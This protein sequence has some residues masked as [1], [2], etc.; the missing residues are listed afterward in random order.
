MDFPF[1]FNQNVIYLRMLPGPIF[2]QTGQAPFGIFCPFV[3]IFEFL[4]Q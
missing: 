2:M 1:Y 3:T 4:S